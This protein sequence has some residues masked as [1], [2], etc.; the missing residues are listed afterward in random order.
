MEKKSRISF[1]PGAAS[2][3]LIL[4]ILSM[5]VLGILSLMSARNAE[6]L[7]SRASMVI[8]AVYSLNDMAEQSF[9][10]LD[11]I[12]AEAAKEGGSEEDTLKRIESRLPDGMTISDRTVSWTESDDVRDLKCA[13]EIVSFTNSERLRWTLH[14]LSAITVDDAWN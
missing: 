2:I 14:R 5:S 13:A 10:E 6:K 4:V 8:E 1:G 3:I 11:A 12:V 7:S 9:A